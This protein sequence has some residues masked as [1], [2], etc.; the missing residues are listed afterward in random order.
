MRPNETGHRTSKEQARRLGILTCILVLITL[1]AQA[2][3]PVDKAKNENRGYTFYESFQGSAN[4]LGQVYKLNSTVGYSF[5]KHLGIDGGV[6]VYS[7]QSSNTSSANG[8]TSGNGLGDAYV[9][10]RLTFNNPILNYATTLTGMAPTGDTDRGFSTGRATFDWN[11]HFDKTIPLIRVTPFANIG[12]ANTVSDTHFFTRPFTSLGTVT[13]LEGGA[14]IKI[15]PMFRVGA[16]VYDIIPSGQQ[17]VFSKLIA[18][19]NSVG[20][21]T[22]RSRSRAGAFENAHETVGG[23]GLV[24]DNGASAW[25]AAHVARFADLEAGY[26][27]SVDFNLNTFEFGIGFDVAYLARKSRGH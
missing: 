23:P 18:R 10:L 6:P 7:V 9:D 11:N 20:L 8:F 27:R 5:N 3:Q 25:V 22:S 4:S 13:H 17:K 16:S 21:G 26:T 2:Q 24:R 14:T 1:A 19:G 15:F 12:V